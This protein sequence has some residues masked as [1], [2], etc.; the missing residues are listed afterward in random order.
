MFIS[1]PAWVHLCG[2]AQGVPGHCVEGSKLLSNILHVLF[3]VFFLV[4]QGFFGS[5]FPSLPLL[6]ARSG[7]L[8]TDPPGSIP[9]FNALIIEVV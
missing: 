7:L 4:F 1:A 6:F 5:Y 8:F 9:R 3:F 2:N